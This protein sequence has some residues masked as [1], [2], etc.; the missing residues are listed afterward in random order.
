MGRP[1]QVST[2]DPQV[3]R[4]QVHPGAAE[5]GD[6]VWNLRQLGRLVSA[7]QGGRL[8]V[9]HRGAHLTQYNQVKEKYTIDKVQSIFCK[10]YF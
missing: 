2:G 1:E 5:S 10:K 3:T 9:R 7:V 4:W 8:V 6:R